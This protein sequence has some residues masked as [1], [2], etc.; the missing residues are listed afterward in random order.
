MFA[1]DM[2]NSILNESYAC[3]TQPT[4]HSL[5][6]MWALLLFI[7]LHLTSSFAALILTTVTRGRRLTS[8]VNM[9]H[10]KLLT[11]STYLVIFLMRTGCCIV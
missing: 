9:G 6:P 11:Q 8:T 2:N 1:P 10:N 5:L 4:I 3:L 7:L